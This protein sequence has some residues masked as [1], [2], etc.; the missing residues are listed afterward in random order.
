MGHHAGDLLLQEVARR[1][2]MS[3]RQSDLVARFGG[4]EFIVVLEEFS[5]S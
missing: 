2:S 1:L 5:E 4:D 3:V